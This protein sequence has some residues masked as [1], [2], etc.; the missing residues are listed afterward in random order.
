MAGGGSRY[1]IKRFLGSGHFGDVYLAK[2]GGRCYAVKKVV[3]TEQDTAKQEIRILRSVDHP[4]IIKYHDHYM[5]RKVLCIVLEYA[6]KGTFEKQ[7]KA[8]LSKEE[9]CV[10]RFIGH[11]SNALNYLHARNPQILHHDL[12]PDNILGVNKP[13]GG[14]ESGHK[15]SC[16]LSDFGIAKL[17]NKPAQEEYYGADAPGVP[18]Y[19]GPEVFR[20]F[21]SYSAASD[22]W[23]LGCV[24]AFRLRGSKRL[25]K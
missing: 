1:D 17:L 22:M 11:M 19:M 12:K 15:I 10:W 23:S 20:D 25:P 4:R 9:W 16:K 2:D 13:A 18:T 24:I 6:D 14:G 21:E 3:N 7:V 5:E 8:N